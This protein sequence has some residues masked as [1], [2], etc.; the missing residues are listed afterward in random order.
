[1]AHGL[2]GDLAH[3]DAGIGQDRVE[4]GGELPASIPDQEPEPVGPLAQVHE[5][6]AGLLQRPRRVRV[7]RD[8]QDVDVAGAYLQH[9]EDVQALQGEG[10]VDVEEVAREYG[11]G[12][13]LQELAPRGVVT[14]HRYRRY[15]G[16]VEDPPDR[17]RPDVMAEAE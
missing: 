11:R 2:R 7:S 6:V 1:L 4:R 16:P 15:A 8:T 9:E 13:R 10:A 12:L 3:G 14:A 5:Q 17:G